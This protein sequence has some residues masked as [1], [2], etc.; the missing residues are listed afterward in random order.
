[1]LIYIDIPQSCLV[2]FFFLWNCS[3]LYFHTNNCKVCLMAPKGLPLLFL[4]FTF[5]FGFRKVQVLGC[6]DLIWWFDERDLYFHVRYFYIEI[7]VSILIF[8]FL[9]FSL[10]V[11]WSLVTVLCLSIWNKNF[12]FGNSRYCDLYSNNDID[13]NI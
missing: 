6:K 3:S 13:C 8:I 5:L 1:M 12:K 9:Y 4:F 7:C 11:L 10:L 2:R